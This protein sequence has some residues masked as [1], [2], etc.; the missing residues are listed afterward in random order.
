MNELLKHKIALQKE[1]VYL[2]SK[3]EDHDTGHIRTAISV[4]EQRV[5]DIDDFID[6]IH[7]KAFEFL[8]ARDKTKHDE[9]VVTHEE[10]VNPM[11]AN[12]YGSL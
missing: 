5:K 3:L 6:G 7:R 1:I 12:M 8:E 10:S 4:L 11:M 9:L 2:T